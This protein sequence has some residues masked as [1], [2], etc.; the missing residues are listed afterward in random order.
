[1]QATSWSRLTDRH[2]HERT[3]GADDGKIGNPCRYRAAAAERLAWS[4]P[5]AGM[6]RRPSAATVVISLAL[7]VVISL[8]LTVPAAVIILE[9][10]VATGLLGRSP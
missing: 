6:A 3:D 5:P 7:T 4:R 9:D 10:S 1:M 2:P 8:A